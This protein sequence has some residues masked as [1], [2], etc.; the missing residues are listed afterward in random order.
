MEDNGLEEELNKINREP[1]K[2]VRDFYPEDM[3]V[4]NFI[5]DVMRKTVISFGYI[6]YNASI[7]EPT[8]LY[9][10][11]SGEELVGEQTYTFT[12]R[13]GREVTLRPEMTPTVARMVAKRKRELT[14]PLR[15]FSIPNMFR[16]ERP[17]KGRLREHWQLNADLFGVKSIDGDV[18]IISLA[19]TL[20]KNFGAKDNNFE[21]KVNSR[22][23]INSILKD[24]LK[25]QDEEGNRLMKLV[26]KREKIKQDEFN[27]EL[28]IMLGDK[29]DTFSKMLK[30]KNLLDFTS[31]LPKEISNS[32]GVK[33]V[34]NLINKLNEIGIKNVVFSPDLVRGFDYYTGIVFEI[35][36]KNP[37]NSR[38]LFGGGRYDDLLDIFGE[39]KVSAVGFGM[40]DV[41]IKDFLNTYNLIPK[42]NSSVDLYICTL[43]NEYIPIANKVAS[44]L[45]SKNI[46][47]EVNLTDKKISDQ[48]KIASKKTASFIICIGENEAKTEKY[49]IKNMETGE[50]KEVGLDKI[51][52]FIK[53]F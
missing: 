8:S 46:N 11:K 51:F 38:S 5:F 32:E 12:D 44:E 48:V 41:T 19:Y 37:E 23:I 35:Y 28:S 7:L 10:A 47:V 42:Y 1:Y 34:Q 31:V 25:L 21:I 18:E 27:A 33:D 9:K 36:D 16:Y 52:D 14:F 30:T 3:F 2:G 13:G 40:G 15:W 39:E 24:F 50:E 49:K 6:E 29:S 45:R 17:Q 22:K 26:D 4:Q 53:R 20:M 43:S